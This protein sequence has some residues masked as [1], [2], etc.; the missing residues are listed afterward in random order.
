V[1][2]YNNYSLFIKA[3]IPSSRSIEAG[4]QEGVQID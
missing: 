1:K 4:G 2:K 3:D